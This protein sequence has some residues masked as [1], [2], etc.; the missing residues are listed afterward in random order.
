MKY[1][2][3]LDT[4]H[5]VNIEPDTDREIP[6]TPGETSSLSPHLE[7]IVRCFKFHIL[8]CIQGL[9]LSVFYILPKA[10][11]FAKKYVVFLPTQ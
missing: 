8:I 3:P 7:K 11:K 6:S 1:G 9:L 2:L 4:Y 10:I 5:I